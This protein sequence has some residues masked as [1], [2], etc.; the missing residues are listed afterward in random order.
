[1]KL[2]KNRTILSVSLI[3][4]L[5][6]SMLLMIAP[7]AT[8]HDPPWDVQ[9]W[10][11]CVVAP[12]PIGVAQTTSIV[13]WLNSPPPTASG[14]QG[15]RWQ[16]YVD[17]TKPDNTKQTLGPFT[18]DAVGGAYT[19]YTPDQTGTYTVLARFPGQTLTGVPGNEGNSNV[20]DIYQPSQSGPVTMTVQQDQIQMTP[21]VPLPDRT[22]YWTRPVNGENRE[23]SMISGNWLMAKYDKDAVGFEYSGNWN[24]YTRAPNS[25]HI[26]WTKELTFGGIVGGEFGVGYG[27]YTGLQYEPKFTPPLIIN[28]ILY[29][30]TADP[31]RYGFQAI[32]IRTGETLW[33]QNSTHQLSIGQ[34]YAYDSPNQ[35]GG[36]PYVWSIEGRTWHMF[37]AFTG[38]Y[39]LSIDNVPSGYKVFGPT[40]EILQYVL[41]TRDHTLSL[42]NSSLS[43]PPP[44]TT[45]AS[46]N[47]WRPD[48]YR[49]ETLNGTVGIQWVTGGNTAPS[50]SSLQ[51]YWNGIIV[52]QASVTPADSAFPTLVHV[53]FN[54]TTGQQI[55]IQNRTDMGKMSFPGYIT[56][57]EGTYALFVRETKQWVAWDM[58]TGNEV[59]RTDPISND[60]GFYQY[61]AGFAYGKFYSAGYD[62]TLHAYDATTGAHLWDYYAGDAGFDTPYGSWPLFGAMIIADGKIIVGTNEHSPSMPLWR[63]EKLHVI[64]AETGKGVWNISGMFSGGRNSLGA[65]A[66]GYIVVGNGYDNRIYCFGKTTSATTVTVPDTSIPQGKQVIIKGS[67]TDQSNGQTCLGIPAK[68]TPAISDADQAAWMEYLYMQH[69]KPTEVTG[70]PVKLSAIDPNG[71]YQDI[72]NAV[73]DSNG[74]YAY[75]WTPPVPG[76]YQITATFEG[77]DAYGPSEATTYLGVETATASA[78]PTSTPTSPTQTQTPPPSTSTPNPTETP[79]AST[80]PSQAPQPTSGMPVT[81]YIAITAA[82]VIIAVAAAAIILRRRK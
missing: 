76:M 32:D 52:S 72:G 43:I 63:G 40:G 57:N 53:G 24:R 3:L 26:A 58:T 18:S 55:W 33:Y 81:T 11:F 60:W 13:F 38:N 44:S 59:W 67:V 61:C 70:V 48:D 39:I 1:M 14:P 46:S 75:M 47:Y 77:S 34:V 82:V 21:E 66:D 69:P 41:S 78:Q 36:I 19:L 49:G 5:S 50:G 12:N 27:Y 7:A 80:S 56:P 8:A 6:F 54:A 16:F 74:N 71:N 4:L 79:S 28:G 37:D 29:W 20:G 25:A 51:W 30:N 73:S 35:H 23:W 10:T 15:D 64:D 65:I 42:W 2:M 31:P 45:G 9:T 68:G 22:Q 62:G 17:V